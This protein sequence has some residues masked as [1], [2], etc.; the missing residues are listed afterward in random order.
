MARRKTGYGA[1]CYFDG[2]LMGRCT[3][4]DS[5]AYTVLMKQCG[6]DAAKVLQI[7]DYFSPELRTI[8]EK[9]AAIQAEKHPEYIPNGLYGPPKNSPWGEVQ[10]SDMLCP[11]IFMVVTSGHGGIPRGD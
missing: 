3:V 6:S 5:E 9:V 7:Y 2:K 4:S 10:H 1:A 11:G 8:F